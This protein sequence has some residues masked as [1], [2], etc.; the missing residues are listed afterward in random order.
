[1]SKKQHKVAG[2]IITARLQLKQLT[3][4]DGLW[5]IHIIIGGILQSTS[6]KYHLNLVL[7]ESPYTREIEEIQGELKGTLLEGE[8]RSKND[9][10]N[11]VIEVKKEMEL[12]KKECPEIEFYARTEEV[13]YKDGKTLLVC[14]IP[15]NV[16]E[17]INQQ[18]TRLET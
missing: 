16:I 10:Q 2:E 6:Q 8:K 14:A 12:A 5:R 17:Q 15:D 3:L 9:L 18:K 13:K 11:R 7:D 1:M 4:K